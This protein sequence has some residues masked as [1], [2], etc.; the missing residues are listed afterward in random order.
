MKTGILVVIL[1]LAA[2][3]G[4]AEE[5]SLFKDGSDLYRYKKYEEAR[6]KFEQAL[7]LEPKD[8]RIYFYLGAAYRMLKQPGKAIEIL[9][10]GL[11]TIPSYKYLFLN[12]LGICYDDFGLQD[13]T[14][15]M[16]YYTMAIAEKTTFADPYLSRANIEVDQ[17]KFQEAKADYVTFLKL[18]P[19]TPQRPEIEKMIAL[20]DQDMANQ[21][22]LLDSIMN[23]LRNASTDTQTD[24]AGTEEF[25]ETEKEDEDILD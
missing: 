2:L 12:D 18:K 20:L 3:P 11:Q 25:K 22:K 4:F 7:A 6:V 1:T 15:A 24:S 21:Q 16:K 17:K 14:I 23:S 8:A 19:D 13:Y 10:K 9:Q 5:N